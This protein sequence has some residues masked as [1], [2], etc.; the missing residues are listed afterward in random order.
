MEDKCVCCGAVIPEGR[1][2][3]PNCEAT[4]LDR[5]IVSSILSGVSYG[6]W[7]TMKKPGKIIPN[8][9]IPKGWSAC[10]KCGKIFKPKKNQV[11]CEISCQAAAQREK[12]REKNNERVREWRMK[13]KESVG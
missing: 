2:V 8:K 1:Q 7:M 10:P 6:K 11:Y 3:C 4:Q 13:Q 5:D 12:D 9:V